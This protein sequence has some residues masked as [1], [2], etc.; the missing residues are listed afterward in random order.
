ML[1]KLTFYTLSAMLFAG[2]VKDIPTQHSSGDPVKM[3]DLSIPSG[4]DWATTREVLCDFSSE[5]L[6]KVYVSTTAEAEPFA[7]FMAGDDAESVKLEIPAS[8]ST[9]YV[10][11]G[12]EEGVSAP[13]PVAVAG[14]R[15]VY[16]VPQKSKDYG[17]LEDGDLNSTEGNVI[18]MPARSQ[19]WGTLLFEDLWPS[20]GDYDFNDFVV[21][22]KVQLYMNNKNKVREMLIGVR[23]NAVGGSLP[24]DLYLQML[25]V[26][27]GQIDEIERVGG[28]N[29][30]EARLVAL[31]NANNVHDAAILKFE[32]IRSNPNKPSGAVYVNTEKGYEMGDGELVE[33]IFMVTFRNSIDYKDVAFRMFDFFIGRETEGGNRAEIHLDG[34]KPT[35]DG[36]VHYNEATREHPNIDG[37]LVP[38]RSNS[39]QTWALNIPAAINHAYEKGSFLEAYPQFAKWVQSGGQQAADWYEHGAKSLLVRK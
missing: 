6:S 1:K 18:Y 27:G 4:F 22:Y 11:Y 36:L 15:A 8:V 32:N 21:N 37:A 28:A 14:D 24:Y 25:G 34:Y 38:Y 30:P 7:V 3:S 13:E 5:N 12:T 29:A 2:C 10:S 20:Y 16:R 35:I 26:Y 33:A 19:G 9:F 31:N 39:G 17:G 23:V